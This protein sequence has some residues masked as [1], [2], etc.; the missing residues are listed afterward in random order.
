MFSVFCF[1]VP[2]FS[3]IEFG[4]IT[5]Q[6]E[7]AAVSF[8]TAI[9]L[10]SPCLELTRACSGNTGK[11]QKGEKWKTGFWKT[12]FGHFINEARNDYKNN[13]ETILS[14]N[15][16]AWNR[17]FVPKEFFCVITFH[18]R[19]HLKTPE[20]H[21]TIPASKPC[22]TDFLCNREIYCKIKKCVLL[23]FKQQLT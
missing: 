14:R 10:G 21:K 19:Y 2:S 20:L 8:Q 9:W 17:K 4:H 7:L 16:Y 23:S 11:I 18:R 22:V 12:G 5:W 15:R 13:S 3:R 1:S 6:L